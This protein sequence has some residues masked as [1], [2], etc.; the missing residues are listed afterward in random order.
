MKAKIWISGAAIAL[1]LT[2]CVSSK[3]HQE[4]QSKYDELAAEH[5]N[6]L[7]ENEECD[8]SLT[9]AK[10][11]LE[12]CIE[13]R[14]QLVSDTIAQNR[15]VR[16]LRG[17]YDDLNKNYQ[18]LL[19]N[20]NTMLAENAREN[21]ELLDRMED[22]QQRLEGKEDSL[23]IEQD[24]LAALSVQLQSRE[25]RVNEL[26]SVIAR[27]DSIVQY[28][29]Q[30][31]SDALLGFEGKG[32]TVEMKNGQVYVSLENRLLF[33]SGSW[34]VEQEGKNALTELAK[35]L[36][37]NPDIKIMVEGHTDDDAYRGSGQVRDNWDLSVMRATSV[38]KILQQNQGIDPQRITAAGRGEHLPVADNDSAEGKAK[39][40]RIEVILTPDLGE[41]VD[42]IGSMR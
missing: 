42:L 28:V 15:T 33:A 38:V 20:N 10:A 9:E 3:V 8:A 24:R 40:R 30:K 37:E 18:F 27:Q 4:L 2:G 14:D 7:A 21:R 6:L 29:Q 17:N 1:T 12:R 23:R 26:E 22:L 19:E 36:A 39:N 41:L 5:D 34:T 32:L 35:V 31:V 16:R 11:M 13:D 25:K